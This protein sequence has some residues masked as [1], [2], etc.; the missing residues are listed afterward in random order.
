MSA[1][2]LKQSFNVPRNPGEQARPFSI[3]LTNAERETLKRKAGSK[4][5]GAYIR[6]KL[7]GDETTPRKSA[8]RSPSESDKAWAQAL[9]GL[10]QSRLASNLNQIAKLAHQ[11]ALPVTP[12]L[13]QE[14]HDACA[15]IK[16]MR[17]MLIKQMGL[18]P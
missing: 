3:R 14:L 11:G 2:S 13:Q 17:L 1:P 5:L 9:A 4:P 15:D 18:R 16:R 6:H 8:A 7:L 10:G 12:E